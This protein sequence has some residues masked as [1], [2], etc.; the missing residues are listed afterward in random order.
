MAA[1]YRCTVQTSAEMMGRAYGALGRRHATILGE[2]YHEGT[3]FF[4]I[5]ALLPV[6]ESFGLADDLRGRTSGVA[7]P[8]LQFAGFRLLDGDPF[9]APP[10]DGGTK[11][12]DPADDGA[13]GTTTSY[14]AAKYLAR[15]RERKGLFVERRIVQNAEKQ[16]TLR[17]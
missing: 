1:V 7:I 8:Q 6:E 12:A 5:D 3:Q 10:E 11:S 9:A 13:G 16:R 15:I 14:L 4:T 17:R 2:E